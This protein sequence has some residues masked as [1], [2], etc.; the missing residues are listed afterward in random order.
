M[1]VGGDVTRDGSI[2]RWELEEMRADFDGMAIPHHVIPGNM[3]TGNKHT[4]RQGPHADR[5]DL[6]RFITR[7]RHLPGEVRLVHGEDEVRAAF[8]THL[9]RATAGKVRVLV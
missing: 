5:D 1:L 6:T 4:D 8:A 2:H 7:L 9:S 3:D